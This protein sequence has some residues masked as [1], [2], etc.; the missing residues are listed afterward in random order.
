VT[1]NVFVIEPGL[2]LDDDLPG[3]GFSL[4]K[5]V[6]RVL[7]EQCIDVDDMA[8]DQ[9]VVRSLSQFDQGTGDDVDEAPGEFAKSGA[10]AFPR[11][12][13]RYAGRDFRLTDV[14]GQVMHELLV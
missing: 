8:L 6:L 12:L 2:N 5:E 3:L 1:R 7:D 9:Q 4:R 11:E 10:I 13:P 14:Y